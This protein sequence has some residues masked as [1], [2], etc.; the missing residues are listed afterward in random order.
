MIP[1]RRPERLYLPARSRAANGALGNDL[2]M[3]RNSQAAERSISY[4]QHNNR[5]DQ[6]L[7]MYIDFIS[8]ENLKVVTKWETQASW[9]STRQNF[10]DQHR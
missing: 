4:T 7:R 10:S 5:F 1:A 9:G 6:R 3:I 8:S 2:S